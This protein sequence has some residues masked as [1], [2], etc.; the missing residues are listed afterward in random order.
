[1]VELL[2]DLKIEILKFIKILKKDFYKYS[3]L[4]NKKNY[5][6]ILK[7]NKILKLKI[8]SNHNI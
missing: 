7:K 6:R 1:M 4:F 8:K 3:I 2:Y 5:F